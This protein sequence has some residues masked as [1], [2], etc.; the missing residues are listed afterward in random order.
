[1]LIARF[2]IQ[3]F[4]VVA[5]A[6]ASFGDEEKLSLVGAFEQGGLVV[7]HSNPEAK[8]MMNGQ[9]VKVFSDGR[10]LIGFGHE[11]GA[12]HDLF[13][14]WPSGRLE[15]KTLFVNQRTY[16][17]QRIEGVEQAKVTPPSS[18]STQITRETREIRAARSA[19]THDALFDA[20]WI[21]PVSGRVT[22]VYGS[23]RFYNGNPRSPHWGI[24]IASPAD[25]PILAP[26]SGVVRLVHQNNFYAGGLVILDHGYGLT[27]SFLHMNTIDVSPGDIIGIGQRLGSVGSTGRSTGPHLDWRI[28]LGPDLRLDAALLPL[29]VGP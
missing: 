3:L 25:T 11:A 8:V 6:N 9:N 24:D 18:A 26:S 2:A 15:I 13:I 14:R 20:G 5:S 23:Q 19:E 29:P 12:E 10:F 21:W 27:S 4:F 7:G 17:I 28:N 22:G 16:A 1:M